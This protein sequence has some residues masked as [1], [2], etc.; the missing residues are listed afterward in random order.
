MKK[1]LLTGAA[2][3]VGSNLLPLLNKENKVYT[4]SSKSVSN[5]NFKID[6]SK[7]WDTNI[8]P[9][10]LDII[11]HLAQSENFREFPGKA[12]D[13]FNVNT[14]SVLKLIDFAYR[15]RVKTFVFA[16]S[17]GIYGNSDFQFDESTDIIY[18]GEMGFYLATKQCSEIILDN[19]SSLLQVIQ[20]RLF[21]VYGKGQR[22]DMLIPRIINNIRNGV[23]LYLQGSSGISINPTHVS[24]AV[25]AIKAS[26]DLTGSHKINIAGPEILSMKELGN[27]IGSS[28]N[29]K[30]QFIFEE[31]EAKN[32]I[33]SISKMSKKLVKPLTT[34]KDGIVDLI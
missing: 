7:D 16:S 26:L 10:D 19:Y 4:I 34:L 9:N 24:D 11:I 17:G 8:L 2:G 15:T 12:V 18:K 1:I 30:P 28:I 21:F 6:F 27:I 13:V 33:G 23:P 5:D 25:R 32:L 22:K 31:K 14:N 29:K 3:L 20:L